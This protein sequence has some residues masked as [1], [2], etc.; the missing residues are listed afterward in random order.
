MRS[1]TVVGPGE[2]QCLVVFEIVLY[3]KMGFKVFK[4]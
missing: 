4:L 3:L 1:F 2:L